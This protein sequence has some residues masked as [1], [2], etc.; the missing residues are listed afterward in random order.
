MEQADR[1]V[2]DTITE[3]NLQSGF[4]WSAYCEKPEQ[5]GQGENCRI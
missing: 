2:D 4:K 1:T 5:T 3:W